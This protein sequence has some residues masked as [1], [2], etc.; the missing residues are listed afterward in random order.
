[1]SASLDLLC[2]T[3]FYVSRTRDCFSLVWKLSCDKTR[4]KMFLL[5]FLVI[6][7]MSLYLLSPDLTS[8][9]PQPSPQLSH[10]HIHNHLL[11]SLDETKCCWVLVEF[12]P[13]QLDPRGGHKSPTGAARQ[14]QQLLACF[15]TIAPGTGCRWAVPEGLLI[16]CCFQ[17]KKT[18]CGILDEP[19]SAGSGLLLASYCRDAATWWTSTKCWKRHQCA[20]PVLGGCLLLQVALWS[21]AFIFTLGTSGPGFKSQMTT[22]FFTAWQD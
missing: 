5:V 6:M 20:I 14:P 17:C 7:L 2:S 22:E 18:W 15:G 11:L 13:E 16:D 12:F 3:I 21:R 4:V 1:M 8:R 19:S 9:F 10:T